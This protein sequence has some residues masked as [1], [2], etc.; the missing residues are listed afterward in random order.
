MVMK[1]LILSITGG[2]VIISLIISLFYLASLAGNINLT[3]KNTLNLRGRIDKDN[4][5]MIIKNYKK[6]RKISKT[7][8][9]YLVVES[10]GGYIYDGFRLIDVLKNDKNLHTVTIFAA[11]MASA[12]VETLPGT[13]FMVPNATFMFH[14]AGGLKYAIDLLPLEKGNADRIGISLDDYR[15]RALQEWWIKGE[16]NLKL[17]IA[18]KSVTITCDDSLNRTFDTFT[19]KSFFSPKEEK[20]EISRCPLVVQPI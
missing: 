6:L 3:D 10:G 11:S 14:R 5:D 12:I 9:I 17:N 16:E 18:D 15:M 13:R 4:V 7:E 19:F 8:T 1:K 2:L 20:V